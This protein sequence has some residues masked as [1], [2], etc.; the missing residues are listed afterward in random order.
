MKF[1]CVLGISCEADA[2]LAQE[3]VPATGECSHSFHH[4]C[5]SRWLKLRSTCPLGRK[6]KTQCLFVCSLLSADDSEFV[7]V[8]AA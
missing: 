8:G 6:K 4:H 7:F 5:I 2:H 3:C 1:F